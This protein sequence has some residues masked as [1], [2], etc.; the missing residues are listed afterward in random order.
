MAWEIRN[1][2]D[3]ERVNL[4]LAENQGKIGGD[5]SVCENASLPALQSVGGD[6][7]VWENA[8]L[9][10]D[11]LQSVGGDLSVWKNASLQADALQSVGGLPYS[12]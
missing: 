5:L 7:S 2:S 9:Q 3:E 11:A 4:H 12:N 10:A 8:S 1:K 6:L